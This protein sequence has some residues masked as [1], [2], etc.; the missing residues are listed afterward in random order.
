[1]TV[2]YAALAAATLLLGACAGR[3][4]QPGAMEDARRWQLSG[5]MG[6]KTDRFAESASINWRQCG[7]VFDVRL[8][9]PLGQT[10]ARIEGRGQQ[11][12]VWMD[13]R[14][15]VTT[16]APE[17]LLQARLG[18]SVPIRALRY[19]VR[20]EAAPGARAD[21]TGP[22]K[23]PETLAQ[24]GWQAR[25]PTWHQNA[26]TAL[27]AKVLLSDGRLQATLLIRDWTL[28]DAVECTP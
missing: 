2:R 27:P 28:G 8:S 23:Q 19:W 20:G 13:G 9:S 4:I 24:F 7:E 26:A 12:T 3:G 6:I 18:W 1:L 25:Y 17:E 15:P 5:K 22:Q 11:L 14:E 21:L 10:V 16:A